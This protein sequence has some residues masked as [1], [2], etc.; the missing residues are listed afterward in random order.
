L[1]YSRSH[2]YTLIEVLVAIAVLAVLSALAVGIYQT[3]LI[4]SRVSSLISAAGPA[5][6]QY[7]LYLQSGNTLTCDTGTQTSA[8]IG[9]S[10]IQSSDNVPYVNRMYLSHQCVIE[11]EARPTDIIP[12]TSLGYFS[13]ILCPTLVGTDGTVQWTC[14]YYDTSGS[15]PWSKYIP[16]ICQ[17]DWYTNGTTNYRTDCGH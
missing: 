11:V 4:K 5:K 13:I 17:Y 9:M 1:L 16:S 6:A 2:A 10:E 14:M 3:Q 8:T 15:K 7:E 12:G